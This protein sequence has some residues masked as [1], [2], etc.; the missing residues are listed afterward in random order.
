MSDAYSNHRHL[1]AE[2]FGEDLV[3][4]DDVAAVQSDVTNIDAMRTRAIAALHAL[5]AWFAAVTT[6]P[7]PSTVYLYAYVDG[8]EQLEEMAAAHGREIYRDGPRWQFDLPLDAP[9]VTAVLLVAARPP[10][11]PL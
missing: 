2:R 7:I 10:D 8:R 1:L 3:P 9:G 4:L 6:L 5:A 11:R